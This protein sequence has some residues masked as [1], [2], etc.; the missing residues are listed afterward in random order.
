MSRKFIYFL[1]SMLV[2][3]SLAFVITGCNNPETENPANDNPA[4]QEENDG[5]NSLRPCCF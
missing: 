5:E 2:I 3:L 1:I 4:V